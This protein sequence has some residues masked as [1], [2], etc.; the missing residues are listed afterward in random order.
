MFTI[1][2]HYVQ[3]RFLSQR[4]EKKANQRNYPS[5]CQRYQI[6]LQLCAANMLLFIVYQL[7]VCNRKYRWF[8]MQT[9]FLKHI[10]LMFGIAE[11]WSDIYWS[12]SFCLWRRAKVWCA[13]CIVD[14]NQVWAV[15]VTNQLALRHLTY[16]N[17]SSVRLPKF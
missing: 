12:G 4:Q 16:W 14:F 7:N 15:E 1:I 3:F 10:Q 9:M 17:A 13:Y 6:H 2:I 11:F 5:I 8:L